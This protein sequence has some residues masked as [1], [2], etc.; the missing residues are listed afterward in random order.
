M[1]DEKRGT[2]D[3]PSAE[4]IESEMERIRYKKRFFGTLLNTVTIVAVVAA[5]SVLLATVFLPVIQVSGESMYPTLMDGD[6]LVTCHTENVSYGDLCCVS[7]QNKTLLKRVIGMP[8]D[9]ISIEPDGTVLVN[10]TPLDE[11]YVIENS[12]GECDISFPYT[13]PDQQIFILGDNRSLSVDSRNSDIGCIKTE[14]IIG[15]VLFRI[16]PIR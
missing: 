12:L 4:Q 1:S 2:V 9:V 3:I 7:W 8:G 15:K 16:W 10:Q 11:P 14:Q 6:I 5:I 13:V